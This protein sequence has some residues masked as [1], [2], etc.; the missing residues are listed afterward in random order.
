MNNSKFDHVN[1]VPEI[2]SYN[3][4]KSKE[5][6]TIS[7]MNKLA[8]YHLSIIYFSGVIYMFLIFLPDSKTIFFTIDL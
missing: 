3:T 5:Y 1:Y 7:S 4:V 6:R 2:I 8:L